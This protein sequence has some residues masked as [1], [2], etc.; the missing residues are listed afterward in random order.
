MIESEN[1]F[2]TYDILIL[3]NKQLRNVS[4]LFIIKQLSPHSKYKY[5]LLSSIK[6]KLEKGYQ[7][8]DL[9]NCFQLNMLPPIIVYDGNHGALLFVRALFVIVLQ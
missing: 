6:E 8:C 1:R 2:V 5:M 7:T 9:N 3:I 4:I